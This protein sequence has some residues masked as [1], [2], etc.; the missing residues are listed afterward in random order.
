MGKKS[1]IIII[2]KYF[3]LENFASLRGK[4]KKPFSFALMFEKLSLNNVFCF[5]DF[6]S[7][8]LKY[9]KFFK[10]GARQF[11]FPKYKTFFHSGILFF[12]LGK[13]PS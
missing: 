5:S 7:S 11:L 8:F 12:E 10:L 13:L 6:T 2:T 3:N 4:Y 1:F 9:Q